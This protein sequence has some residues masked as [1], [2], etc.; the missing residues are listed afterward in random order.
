MTTSL[1]APAPAVSW[2]PAAE[3]DPPAAVEAGTLLAVAAPDAARAGEGVAGIRRDGAVDLRATWDGIPV[4]DGDAVS[5]RP[6]QVLEGPVD[7]GVGDRE[8][9]GALR[10][11]GS[12]GAGRRIGATGTLI[13]AG[14][15]DRATLVAGGD[16]IV[17]GRAG[18][19]VLTAGG[20]SEMRRAVVAALAGGADDLRAL[21]VL[22]RR[23][24]AVAAASGRA[25]PAADRVVATLR[26]QRLPDLEDRLAQADAALARAR[27]AWP[28]LAPELTRELASARGLLADPGRS[29]DPV[30]RLDAAAAFL[31]A[32]TAARPGPEPAGIRIGAAH[33][34]Q[35]TCPGT[36]R[37]TGTGAT[38]CEIEA[39]GDLFAVGGG[40]GIRGGHVRLGGR[41]RAAELGGRESAALRIVIRDPRP[42]HVVQADV[43]NP[44][45]ELAVGR[46]TV[47]VDQRRRDLRI[48]L[49]AGRLVV[50]SS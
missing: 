34:T 33:G 19:S 13:V 39:G 25:V 47:R 8:V 30:A 35:L 23:L 18:A 1:L 10:V 22:A 48:T 45:V 41:L 9:R 16:L 5:V 44:G 43:A 6:L 28:S 14:M 15:A 27:R 3:A 26:D 24:A 37:F 2:T 46:E 20:A 50:T 40:G 42:G 31:L 36:V 7:R 32:A 21:V 38:D 4:R 17:D 11:E 12:V 29:P 49:E